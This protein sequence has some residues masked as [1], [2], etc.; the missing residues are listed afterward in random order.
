MRTILFMEYADLARV[1]T[2]FAHVAFRWLGLAETST[3]AKRRPFEASRLSLTG[4]QIL[5][6]LRCRSR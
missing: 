3:D 2:T 4:P 6:F 1:C 5:F